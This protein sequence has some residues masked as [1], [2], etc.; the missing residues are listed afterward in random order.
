MHDIRSIRDNPAA[1]DAAWAR[2]KLEPQTPRILEL[3]ASL[4]AATT[5]KQEAEAARNAASKQIGQAKAQKD[6]AKA[7]ALMAEVAEIKA[8]GATTPQEKGARAEA[9]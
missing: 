6:E 7:S 3:D 9:A 1:F 5:K 8:S 4:R 2:K